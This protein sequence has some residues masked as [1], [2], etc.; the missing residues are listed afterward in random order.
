MAA[1][2]ALTIFI[3]CYLLFVFF[4]SKRTFFAIA[5]A[6]LL[7]LL[8][9]LSPREAFNQVNWNVM[10]IFV[11]MLFV[12]DI[13]MESKAPAFIAEK[14]VNRS[15]RV[16]WAIFFV[17]ILT[18]FISAFVENVATVLIVAPIALSISKRLK[19]S[20]VNMMIA[21]A[22]S[23]NLQGA[24]TLVGDPPS[25]L[26]GGFA[27]MNFMDFFFY[28]GR[29]GIF[30]AIQL[31]AIASFAVLYYF[32]KEHREKVVT[33]SVEKVKSWLPTV[34]LLLLILSLALSSFFDTGFSGLSGL[35]CMFFGLAAIL[36]NR[37]CLKSMDWNTAFFLAAV[38]ILVGGITATGW[39]AVLAAFFSAL[40]GQ[41]VLLG[42]LLVIVSSVILSAFIDN[43]PYLAAMLPVMILMSD[44]LQIHPA[45][46]L[47]GL[48][49]GASIGGNITPI[50]A[51]ANIVAC[52]ILKKEGYEVNFLD[53]MKIGLPFTLAAV[54][55]ASAFIW[56]VWK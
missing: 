5:G 27:K 22:I 20:P 53:F 1:S 26:L 40:I 8:G 50:G 38:F 19:I 29:P 41:N 45:L 18:S 17:C 34:L 32:F 15:G 23:S 10:G 16:V 39:I 33:I 2:V 25:M 9:V 13:F 56:F 35:I 7:V 49:I 47:F 42:Y 37:G 51:S 11:G 14:I 36:W 55:A 43:V 28:C 4:P 30:F 54:T 44:K 12:A 24:A 48:L 3:A 46:F 52:G 31:G 6:G 21:I